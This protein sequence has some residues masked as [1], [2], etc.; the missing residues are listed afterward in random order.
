MVLEGTSENIKREACGHAFK[1]KKNKAIYI[2]FILNVLRGIFEKL[3]IEMEEMTMRE[4][5]WFLKTLDSL[6]LIIN[7]FLPIGV[8][9]YIE[10]PPKLAAKKTNNVQNNDQYC[11]KFRT[12]TSRR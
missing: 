11:F 2:L 8:S 9:S 6:I 4:S 7:P 5:G 1:T 3:T 10:L 12:I